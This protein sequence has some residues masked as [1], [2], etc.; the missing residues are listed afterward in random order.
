[1]KASQ[2]FEE[3]QLT[4][5]KRNSMKTIRDAISSR[6]TSKLL[7]VCRSDRGSK[8]QT[9]ILA[10]LMSLQVDLSSVDTE[11]VQKKITCSFSL[12]A[13]VSPLPGARLLQGPCP[14]TQGWSL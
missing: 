8:I 9:H 7:K 13:E 11:L 12:G 1:M 5:N 3:Y 6:D 4:Q 2:T 10:L 14:D